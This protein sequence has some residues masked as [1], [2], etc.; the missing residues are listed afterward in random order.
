LC[1]Y[2]ISKEK[3]VCVETAYW[4]HTDDYIRVNHSRGEEVPLVVMVD[5]KSNNGERE[6]SGGMSLLLRAEKLLIY[7][8]TDELGSRV[9]TRDPSSGAL[10]G[11]I[12][13]QYGGELVEGI[14]LPY[15]TGVS[16]MRS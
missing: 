12:R 8:H 16:V 6:L 9:F 2:L 11:L 1:K 5:L 15:G 13:L 4:I 10:R 3:Y 14:L 7:I